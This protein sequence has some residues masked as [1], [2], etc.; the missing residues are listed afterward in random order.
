MVLANQRDERGRLMNLS[1]WGVVGGMA[2][3]VA[4]VA[5][6]DSLL[7]AVHDLRHNTRRQSKADT[8]EMPAAFL[9]RKRGRTRPTT[10][11]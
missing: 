4:V 6:L 3:I 2:V 7:R 5:G 1:F 11:G 10:Q 9:R 8:G